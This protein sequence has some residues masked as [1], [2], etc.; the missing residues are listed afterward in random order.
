VGVVEIP[1]PGLADAVER[2]D[3]QAIAA[4]VAA[5]AARTPRN[6]RALVL[7]CTHYEFLA[8]P[9][10]AALAGHLD[11]PESLT[12]L[13]SARAVAEQALRRAAPEALARVGHST[14]TVIHGGRLA[15]LPEAAFAYEFGRGL[16]AGLPV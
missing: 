16:A 4:A 10:R 12:L 6:T 9:I 3:E 5:A 8:E 13:G 15:E 2:A 11:E 1:C 7:G 14:L